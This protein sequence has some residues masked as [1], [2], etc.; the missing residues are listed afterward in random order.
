MKKYK[1]F[2]F[3]KEIYSIQ[4]FNIIFKDTEYGLIKI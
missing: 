3:Y 1:K 4:Y 2:I